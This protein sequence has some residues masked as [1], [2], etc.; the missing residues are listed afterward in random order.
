MEKDN[1]IMLSKTTESTKIIEEEF[2][3]MKTNNK[4]KEKYSLYKTVVFELLKSKK[5]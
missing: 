5:K 2:Y 4:N 1:T 3:S